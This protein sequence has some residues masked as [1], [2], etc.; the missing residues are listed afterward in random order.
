MGHI[1]KLVEGLNRLVAPIGK[2]RIDAL[3]VGNDSAA[4]F[5]GRP[6]GPSDHCGPIVSGC[7]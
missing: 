1:G 7:R 2:R 3:V 5:F 4:T 6:F